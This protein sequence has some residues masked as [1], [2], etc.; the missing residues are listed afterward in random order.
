MVLEQLKHSVRIATENNF[1]RLRRDLVFLQGAWK[2][3]YRDMWPLHATQ[4]MG[5][6]SSKIVQLFSVAT[7]ISAVVELQ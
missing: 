3:A 1:A 4:R 7:L 2:V 6:R 5:Q